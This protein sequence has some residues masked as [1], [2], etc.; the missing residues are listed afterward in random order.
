M[1]RGSIK[2]IS[3][4]IDGNTTKLVDAIR[5]PVNKSKELRD[6]LKNVDKALKLNPGNLDL[7]K[8]KQ[9]LLK[10]AVKATEDELKALKDAQQRY[11]DSGQ[12]VNA[13]GYTELERQIEVVSK[14]LSSLKEEQ[15]QYNSV[16]SNVS[17]A[18]RKFGEGAEAAG[19]KLMP[20]STGVA[21]LG[22]A[23]VKITGD[24]DASMSQV[25]AV[26][27]ATAEEIE[28]LRAKAREMGATTKFSASEAADAMNYMAMAEPYRPAI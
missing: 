6:S 5:E 23:A 27:G 2:G 21:A 3:I 1:G 13:E 25:G 15:A 17:D 11:I 12:D 4:E 22:T 19:K 28:S 7:V 10:E 26:S 18:A 24:F 16:L 20:L 14:S 9:T 8:Q